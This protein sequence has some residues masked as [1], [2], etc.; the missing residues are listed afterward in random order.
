MEKEGIGFH[1]ALKS[2]AERYGIPMPQRSQYADEDSKLR[3]SLMAMHELAQ[4]NF[5]ANLGSAAGEAARAYVAKRGLAEET[6]ERFGIGY[7]DRTGRAL[8]RLFEQQ[9]FSTAQM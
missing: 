6:L 5:R 1:E 9:Q 2:L 4:E 3:G 7:S 8:I